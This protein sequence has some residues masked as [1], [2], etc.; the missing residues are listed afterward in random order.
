MH[1][2]AHCIEQMA[3]R[4]WVSLRMVQQH[5]NGTYTFKNG[6]TYEGEWVNG[7]CMEKALVKADGDTYE[8][9]FK[10]DAMHGKGIYTYKNG[11]R[12]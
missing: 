1:G 5:G 10:D 4:M 6:N 2:K 11:E 8:G 3:I 7:K 9:E 12:L